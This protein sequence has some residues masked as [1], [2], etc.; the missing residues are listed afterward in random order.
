LS[1]NTLHV[2]AKS[3]DLLA[4]VEHEVREKK[5]LK[6]FAV[7]PDTVENQSCGPTNDER[8]VTDHVIELSLEFGIGDNRHHE[9]LDGDADR[10]DD[11]ENRPDEFLRQARV[12]GDSSFV[13]D[14]TN[15]L[16]VLSISWLRTVLVMVVGINGLCV[17][18]DQSR[19]R[20]PKVRASEV[21]LEIRS[22]I[23]AEART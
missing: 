23:L 9:E 5:A 21:S 16:L 12:G 7:N 11:S 15:E 3:L 13:D 1:A 4:F 18:R 20:G 19:K 6:E 10:V 14:C 22:G 17:V 2:R 8:L